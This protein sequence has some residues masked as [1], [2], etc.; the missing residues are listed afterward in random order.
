MMVT[1]I[2]YSFSSYLTYSLSILDTRDPIGRGKLNTQNLYSRRNTLA[3]QV[4]NKEI[5]GFED[6]FVPSKDELNAMYQNLKKNG[7]GDFKNHYYWT[8]CKFQDT[9]HSSWVQNFADGYQTDDE[10]DR[11]NYVRPVR[12]F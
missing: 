6:W 11:W 1:D 5:D 12:Y 9:G 7:L 2:R 3:Y 10:R 4:W 8:S